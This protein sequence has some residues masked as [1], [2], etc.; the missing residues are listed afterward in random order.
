MIYNKYYEN[1]KSFSHS[2]SFDVF[3][4]NFLSTSTISDTFTKLLETVQIC[5]EYVEPCFTVTCFDDVVPFLIF[6]V[7]A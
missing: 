3:I 7:F 1:N 6:E 4:Y 2:V 5:S